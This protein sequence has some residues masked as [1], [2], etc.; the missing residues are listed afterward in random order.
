MEMIRRINCHIT[1]GNR[2]DSARRHYRNANAPK[3]AVFSFVAYQKHSSTTKTIPKELNSTEV[4]CHVVKNELLVKST[5][6]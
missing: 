1:L 5:G 4:K 6:R 3:M 2:P